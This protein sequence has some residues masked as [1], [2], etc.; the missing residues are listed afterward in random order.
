M[1]PEEIQKQ[2]AGT[3]KSRIKRQVGI[4]RSFK[5]GI[6]VKVLPEVREEINAL[7]IYYG[8]SPQRYIERLIVDTINHNPEHVEEGLNYLKRTKG[9]VRLALALAHD[10]K[11]SAIDPEPSPSPDRSR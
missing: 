9:S 4:D 10:E 11:L 1:E 8:M 5:V 7:A 6:D 3:W 2:E